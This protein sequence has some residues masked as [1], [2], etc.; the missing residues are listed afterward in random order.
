MRTPTPV[1]RFLHN[2]GAAGSRAPSP[3]GGRLLSELRRRF[4]AAP[5]TPLQPAAPRESRGHHPSPAAGSAKPPRGAKLCSAE[6]PGCW[7]PSGKE[8]QSFRGRRRNGGWREE[9][10]AAAGSA[11]RPGRGAASGFPKQGG[12]RN[13]AQAAL[14]APRACRARGDL[15][16]RRRQFVPILLAFG[17]QDTVSL[18]LKRPRRAW[19]APLQRCGQDTKQPQG[20]EEDSGALSCPAAVRAGG[21]GGHR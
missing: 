10:T 7:H 18:D 13:K 15:D 20:E 4:S 17:L 14:H 11:Q 8:T 6:L 5:S 21:W 9:G 3:A 2:Q 1:L 19:V 12:P 16:C